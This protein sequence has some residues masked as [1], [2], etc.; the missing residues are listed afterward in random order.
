M[1]LRLNLDSRIYVTVCLSEAVECTSVWVK[2]TGLN[3]RMSGLSAFDALIGAVSRFAEEV[4]S[5]STTFIVS[6][7]PDTQSDTPSDVDGQT[8]ERMDEMDKKEEGRLQE[9]KEVE[10]EKEEGTWRSIS[11]CF[12]LSVLL[13]WGF[14]RPL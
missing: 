14:R 1:S 11:V 8:D 13:C 3:E 6:T 10:K 2:R 12:L 5:E 4:L 7:P 9:E